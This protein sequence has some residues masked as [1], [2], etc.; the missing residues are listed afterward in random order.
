[1]SNTLSPFEVK[2]KEEQT[3]LSKLY[4]CQEDLCKLSKHGDEDF[5]NILLENVIK[6]LEHKIQNKIDLV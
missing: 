2:L 6:N 1:M 4:E 5:H 3:L